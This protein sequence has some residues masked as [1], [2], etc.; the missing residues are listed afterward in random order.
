MATFLPDDVVI[1]R[2]KASLAKNP[3]LHD[4]ICAAIMQMAAEKI[5]KEAV[6]ED[7]D[8]V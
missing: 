4:L 3:R 7:R 2:I 5:T 1:E 8:S 6:E